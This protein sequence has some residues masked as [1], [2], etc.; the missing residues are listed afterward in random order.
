MRQ[1]DYRL[2]RDKSWSAEIVSFIA[3]IYEHKGR[4][5]PY[6]MQ[7]PIEL[8]RLSEIATFQSIESSNKIE[9]IETSSARLRQIVSETATPHTSDEQ[10][11]TGYRDVLKTIDE[12][13]EYIPLTAD[14][15]LQLHRDL[16]RYTGRHFGGKFKDT[17]NYIIEHHADGRSFVR[18]IPLEPFETPSAVQMICA[19]YRETLANE[20]INP[21][22]LIPIFLCDFLRIH[23]FND[24]NGRT[25]RLLTTLLLYQSG[26]YAGKYISL[27]KKIEQ[28][29]ATYY[30][31][32]GAV[33]GGWHEGENDYTPFIKYFLSILL[34]SYRDLEE[35]VGSV[36]QKTTSYE[37]VRQVTDNILGKFTKREVLERAPSYGSS[38]VEAAL[39]KLVEEGHIRHIGSGRSTAYVRN[40]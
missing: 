30:D 5:E 35:R 14:I 39:K 36:D 22:I 23:P 1:F 8:E 17:Q 7:K 31:A 2:L 25:S 4:Q 21:L 18:F 6:Y 3:Q 9:G 40:F 11:I 33:S 12:S 28:T 13:Y 20:L 16:F 38:S 10:E 24:G 27:E 19:S 37:K 15:I 26:F 32:L 29:K 34:N